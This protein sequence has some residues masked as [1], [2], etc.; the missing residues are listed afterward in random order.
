M[1]N[2]RRTTLAVASDP[3]GSASKEAISPVLEERRVRLRGPLRSALAA[4]IPI[5]G[6]PDVREL[7]LEKD[8]LDHVE[9]TLGS[10][11]IHVAAGLLCALLALEGGAAVV[12]GH[13]GRTFSRLARKAPEKATH[14]FEK[15]WGSSIP[16][17]R[18]LIKTL[19]ALIAQAY[20]EHDVVRRKL[21][22]HPERWISE[23]AKKRLETWQ[24]EI[25]RHDALILESDPLPAGKEGA[26]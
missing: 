18:L 2:T 15:W 4:L 6:P 13:G 17:I 19:K 12:P 14:Y 1:I 9:L 24:E 8:I 25:L 5:A 21:E 11:P 7:D 16:P 10:F 20:Y 26:A 3:P 23:V 22:Y